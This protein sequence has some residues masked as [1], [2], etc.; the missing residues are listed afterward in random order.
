MMVRNMAQQ[1]E[2]N[3]KVWMVGAE[4]AL[5]KQRRLRNKVAEWRSRR[6]VDLDKIHL[7]GNQRAGG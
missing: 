6:D 1:K 5:Q 2:R 7:N 4:N 3:P